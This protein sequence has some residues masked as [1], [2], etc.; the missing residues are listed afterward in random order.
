[1]TKF[2]NWFSVGQTVKSLITK[3]DLISG[4]P[5]EIVKI[6]PMVPHGEPEIFCWVKSPDTDYVQTLVPAKDLTL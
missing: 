6:G 4:H 2:Q 3:G 1:M 5:Y